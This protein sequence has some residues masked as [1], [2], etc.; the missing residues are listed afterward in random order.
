MKGRDQ[1]EIT[2]CLDMPKPKALFLEAV[3]EATTP[4]ADPKDAM[5]AFTILQTLAR[6]MNEGTKAYGDRAVRELRQVH[7]GL[8]RCLRAPVVHAG[9]G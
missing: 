3:G 1:G 6:W 4:G 8:H 9:G 2:K 7:L 5:R